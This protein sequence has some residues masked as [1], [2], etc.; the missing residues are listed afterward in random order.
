MH[1]I[2]IIRLKIKHQGIWQRE[3]KCGKRE[4]RWLILLLV[5]GWFKVKITRL[6][7]SKPAN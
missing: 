7:F 5:H 3:G 1:N 2:F 6:N 4:T